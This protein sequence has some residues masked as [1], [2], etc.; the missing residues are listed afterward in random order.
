MSATYQWGGVARLD[1]VSAPPS[2]GLVFYGPPA[3]HVHAMPLLS[4]HDLVQSAATLAAQHRTSWHDSAQRDSAQHEAAQHDSAQATATKPDQSSSQQN[5]SFT[6][7][8]SGHRDSLDSQPGG[9]STHQDLSQVPHLADLEADDV[10]LAQHSANKQW[11]EEEEHPQL[12][13]EPNGLGRPHTGNG[14]QHEIAGEEDDWDDEGLF[15][16]TSVLAR[17]GLRVTEKASFTAFDCLVCG[18]HVMCVRGNTV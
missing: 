9:F 6:L 3:L 18:V 13:A 8:N 16:E 2:T 11:Q 14:H 17:G 7:H 10:M 4:Q 5:D 15:A 12:Q 1:L